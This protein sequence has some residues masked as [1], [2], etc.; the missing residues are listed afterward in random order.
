MLEGIFPL[1][2]ATIRCYAMF[3]KSKE[4]QKQERTLSQHIF[5]VYEN[6][7]WIVQSFSFA[8]WQKPKLSVFKV[9]HNI[10][11]DSLNT[12]SKSNEK[13]TV[14]NRKMAKVDL[15]VC[16]CVYLLLCL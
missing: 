5:L 16:M 12:F 14:V 2:I 8:I 6:V 10:I 1:A 9:F 11:N 4:K 3:K 13:P 15:G 7:P